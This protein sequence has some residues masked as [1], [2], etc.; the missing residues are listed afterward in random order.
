[1]PAAT[2]RALIE[3][4]TEGIDNAA[5]MQPPSL[6]YAAAH[7][8]ATRAAAAVVAARCEPLPRGVAMAV[9]SA[10]A[11]VARVAPELVEWTQYFSGR[12]VRAA[13]ASANLPHVVTR[14]E[15]DAAVQ[16]AR[17]FVAQVRTALGIDVEV[18]Q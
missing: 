1:M 2:S 13:A 11:I 5:E 4:A 3:A 16:A 9:P 8:A 17:T 15:T 10:W 14:S 7:L 12:T 6:A 18:T